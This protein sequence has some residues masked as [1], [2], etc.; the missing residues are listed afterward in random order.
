MIYHHY[1]HD[2]QLLYLALKTFV[3]NMKYIIWDTHFYGY[4]YKYI[5][6]LL[7]AYQG[8][9]IQYRKNWTTSMRCYFWCA[10]SHLI[11]WIMSICAHMDFW[12]KGVCFFFLSWVWRN[13]KDGESQITK[14]CSRRLSEWRVQVGKEPAEVIQELTFVSFLCVKDL[15]HFTLLLGLQCALMTMCSSP[16]LKTS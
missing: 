9:K 6:L 1:H 7:S 3:S 2:Y 13:T 16:R 4:L 5:Y 10:L 8:R 11:R 14:K 12:N 15:A